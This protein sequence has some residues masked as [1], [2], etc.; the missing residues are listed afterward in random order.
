MQRGLKSLTNGRRWPIHETEE[1]GYT[2]SMKLDPHAFHVDPDDP[3]TPP[4]D[5]WDAMSEVFR[6]GA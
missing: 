5:V 1:F 4:Q 3:R 2:A 6:R